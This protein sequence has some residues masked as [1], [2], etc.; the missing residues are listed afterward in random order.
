MRAKART[1]RRGNGARPDSGRVLVRPELG[2]GPAGEAR[3]SAAER[4]KGGGV[5]LGFAGEEGGSVEEF[6]VAG[7]RKKKER[8]RWAGP[9][10]YREKRERLLFFS[11]KDSNNS[12]KI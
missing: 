11:T 12:I 5:G 6:W 1:T 7:E 8:G 9:K 4:G 2:D 3:L 10:G